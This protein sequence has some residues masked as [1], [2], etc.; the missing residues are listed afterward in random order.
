[1]PVSESQN[2]RGVNNRKRFL[3]AKD[4]SRL[5]S[6]TVAVFPIHIPSLRLRSPIII[7]TPSPL[8]AYFGSL[9]FHQSALQ[10]N[11]EKSYVGPMSSKDEPQR[12]LAVAESFFRHDFTS[13]FDISYT[14]DS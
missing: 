6:E 4:A 10:L 9:F 11:I 5:S 1:L 12:R 8:A 7:G 3:N 14:Q 2:R 13:L